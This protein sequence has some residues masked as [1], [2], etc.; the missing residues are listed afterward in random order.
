MSVGPVPTKRSISA[1]MSGAKRSLSVFFRLL[2]GGVALGEAGLAELL[3]DFDQFG[4]QGLVAAEAGNL[5]AG[6]VDLVGAEGAVACLAVELEGD[7]PVGAVRLAAGGAALAVGLATGAGAAGQGA[8]PHVAEVGDKLDD[9][10]A[11]G[12]KGRDGVRQWRP[13]SPPIYTTGGNPDTNHSMVRASNLAQQ[14]ITAMSCT[15]PAPAP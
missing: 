13:S 11:A 10:V 7:R 14:K 9:A 2:G 5:L 8:G 15:P 6:G 12:C 3:A 1:R 4:G